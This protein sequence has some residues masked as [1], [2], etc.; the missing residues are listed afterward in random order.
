MSAPGPA[1]PEPFLQRLRRIVPAE[2]W[3]ECVASFSRGKPTAFR[4]NTL[5][6]A[7]E[8]VVHR[9]RSSG[10]VVQPVGWLNEA[11][12]V[13]AEQRQALVR[14]VEAEEGLIYIQN[15]SSMIPPLVLAPRPGQHVLDLAAAPGGKTI[16]IAGLMENR[17]KI[18]AV[19]PIRTRMYKLQ[20][21]L[22]RFGVT[23]ARTYLTDGRTV[24]RKVPEQFDRVLLD[25]P[26]S[27]EARFRLD[28]LRSWAH[29]SLRKVRE[30]ARKQKGL[31]RAALASLKPG[32]VLVYCTCS[33][34]PEE[35]E[36]VIHDA[37]EY[38]GQ[39]VEVEV[40]DLGMGNVQPGLAGWEGRTYRPE[41]TRSVRLLPSHVMDGFFLCKL[42]KLASTRWLTR[43]GGRRR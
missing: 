14:S 11:F 38:F 3:E 32:G 21:N 5:K 31:L 36:Q 26:C 1:L 25:A 17:G 39:A 29:W 28:D 37:L 4:V 12:L 30:S 7:V 34:A 10:F 8:E 23:I 33:F 40:M 13:G 18:A 6:A 20:T 24:G 35:N 42:R 15:P 43:S 41:V 22:R 27:S 2:R 16:H 19:E 9:L